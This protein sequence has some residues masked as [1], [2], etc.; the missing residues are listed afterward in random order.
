MFA[1]N[2]FIKAVIHKSR[3]K[4]RMP[5]TGQ[6]PGLL[7][8]FLGAPLKINGV[9]ENIQ[10]NLTGMSLCPSDTIWS[11]GV[12]GLGHHWF[13]HF[14]MYHFFMFTFQQLSN[15]LKDPESSKNDRFVAMELLKN[16]TIAAGMV[17]PGCQDTGTAIVM[18]EWGNLHSPLWVMN[19]NT[20]RPEQNGHHFAD[21]LFKWIFFFNKNVW[22]SI[23]FSM[24]FIPRGLIDNKSI[25]VFTI[26]SDNDI[27]PNKPQ[28]ITFTLVQ[29]MAWCHQ[30]TS[31]YLNQCWPRSMS[32]YGVTRPQW[33]NPWVGVKS[34]TILNS[35][36]IQICF[37]V[38]LKSFS[39]Q[40][41]NFFF[42]FN[43]AGKKGQ[44]VWTKGRDEEALSRGVYNTYTNTNLRYSQVSV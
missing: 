12:S 27:E 39:M 10:G 41:V 1:S 15:I 22:I 38:S 21:N 43:H 31:H 13:S 40:R 16:A 26:G 29:V 20:L 6:N 17:L 24:N 28:A 35:I 32:P 2:R 19:F 36:E 18:G 25:P 23:K 14:P 11:D 5:D 7:W 33:V 42:F 44:F 34:S 4:G 9:P 30:A 8:I 3:Q 37:Y